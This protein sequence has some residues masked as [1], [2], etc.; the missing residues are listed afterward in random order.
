MSDRGIE[1]EDVDLSQ[2]LHADYELRRRDQRYNTWADSAHTVKKPQTN[3]YQAPYLAACWAMARRKVEKKKGA[4]L[5]AADGDAVQAVYEKIL[6]KME[7]KPLP[8]LSKPRSRK[9]AK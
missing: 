6:A 8:D 2:S 9:S 1:T 3:P 7:K 5:T 4:A